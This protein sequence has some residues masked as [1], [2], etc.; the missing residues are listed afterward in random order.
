MIELSREVPI[1]AIK[2]RAPK[3]PYYQMLVGESFF[4]P[5]QNVNSTD[6]ARVTGFKFRTHRCVEDGVTGMRIFRI[7]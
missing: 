4:V 5:R 3:Y 7:S 6:W 1:P 2:H